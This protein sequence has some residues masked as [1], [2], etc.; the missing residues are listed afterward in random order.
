MI[1]II[2][3]I[4]K[5]NKQGKD[6][7]TGYTNKYDNVQV[8]VDTKQTDVSEIEKA[9]IQVKPKYGKYYVSLNVVSKSQVKK[10]ELNNE[11]YGTFQV[12]RAKNGVVYI[13]SAELESIF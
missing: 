1:A 13:V 3:S 10:E 8:E 7:V 4:T 12:D 9:G 11:Y 6:K 2:G 5:F